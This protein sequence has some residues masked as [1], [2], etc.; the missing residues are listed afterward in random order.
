MKKI[1]D[2]I[3]GHVF[4]RDALI[5]VIAAAIC[6]AIWILASTPNTPRKKKSQEV[7]AELTNYNGMV[8]RGKSHIGNGRDGTYTLL[9]NDPTVNEIVSVSVN[10]DAFK[11]YDIDDTIREVIVQT[12][13]DIGGLIPQYISEDGITCAGREVVTEGNHEYLIQYAL[14]PVYKNGEVQKFVKIYTGL[15][16]YEDCKYCTAR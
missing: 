2:F 6:F 12:P 10:K 8:V 3:K 7:Y 16:H 15:C 9:I 1:L 5:A 11:R 4:L 14:I 13:D